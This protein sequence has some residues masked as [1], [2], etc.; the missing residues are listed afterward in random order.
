LGSL[1][2]LQS[3]KELDLEGTQVTDSGL[4]HLKCLKGLRMLNLKATNV[5]AGGE[6]VLKKELPRCNISYP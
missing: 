1:E 5:T 4:E 6:A 2:G 3:L